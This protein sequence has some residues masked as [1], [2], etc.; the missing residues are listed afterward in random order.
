MKRLALQNLRRLTISRIIRNDSAYTPTKGV[1]PVRLPALPTPKKQK[2]SWTFWE[3][4]FKKR[5]FKIP[6][7]K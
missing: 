3:R 4:L 5:W 2:R 7:Q 6:P 1:M